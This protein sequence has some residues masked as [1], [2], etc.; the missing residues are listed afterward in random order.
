MRAAVRIAAPEATVD[1]FLVQ[2]MV[3]ARIEVIAGV[4]H[5]PQFGPA[6]M[7]GLGGILVE[8]IGHVEFALPPLDAPEVDR[9]IERTGLAKL[10]G[11]RGGARDTDRDAVCGAV[12]ALADLAASNLGIEQVEINPLVV[13]ADGGGIAAVDALI[14]LG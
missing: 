10:L 11:A 8:A 6:V 2:R 5:S 7:L 12:L 4:T 9:M 14:V 3:K 1:G 13:L